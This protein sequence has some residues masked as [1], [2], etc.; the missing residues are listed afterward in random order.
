MNKSS[1]AVRTLSVVSELSQLRTC[2]WSAH[3]GIPDLLAVGLTTGR[4]LLL[5]LDAFSAPST[6]PNEDNLSKLSAI[7]ISPR[8]S[9]PC[10]VVSFCTERPSYL[11]VGLEKARGE[12]LLVFD[13]EVHSQ[14]LAG[15]NSHI[16]S[17]FNAHYSRAT[18]AETSSRSRNASPKP[19]PASGEPRPIFQFGS[20]ETVSSAT[21][22]VSG[23][24]SASPLLVAGMGGKW[25]RAFDLR[26]PPIT[27]ATWATRSINSISPN[28]YNGHQFASYGDDGVIKLWDLRKTN[29]ALLSF[30][31]N[32][33]GAIPTRIRASNA[34]KPLVDI[35]WNPARRG[36]LATLEKES[37]TIRVWHVAD[38]PVARL[39]NK[40][41]TFRTEIELSS[42]G[43]EEMRLPTVLSDQRC[44][45]M[46]ITFLHSELRL[47]CF[48]RTARSFQYPLASFSFAQSSSASPTSTHFIG[49]SRDTASPGTS[50]HRIEIV[51]LLTPQQCAFL[52]TSLVISNDGHFS[53]VEIPTTTAA[54][55]AEEEFSQAP[56]IGPRVSTETTN[57]IMGSRGRSL[58]LTSIQVPGM[59]FAPGLQPHGRSSTP[60]PSGSVTPRR[61]SRA[62]KVTEESVELDAL[63][64]G[65]LKSLSSDPAVLLRVW[66]EKGY[67]SNVHLF[68]SPL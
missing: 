12:S 64:F 27:V 26:A 51:E 29:D 23:S 46:C 66:V 7:Q 6:S 55:L 14:A 1:S 16:S 33:A 48:L 62:R 17:T 41:G 57:T 37:S 60:R 58:S 47:T 5:R 11:A 54:V 34:M 59:A 28:P 42:G 10:N 22:L 65:G 24:N 20:S 43:E 53:T 38:G 3:S 13:I 63:S 31:E 45:S 15:G 4:T 40:D 61:L 18:T 36:I 52:E 44:E 21:F 9:R 25:L 8:H 39:E 67:G 56:L 2:A 68:F 19:T 50:G 30:S 32:D 49:V 35:V